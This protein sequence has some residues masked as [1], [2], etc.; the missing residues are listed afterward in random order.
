MKVRITITARHVEV[1]DELRAR[2]RDLVSRLTKVAARPHSARVTFGEDHGESMIEIQVL[3]A[4]GK[5]HVARGLGVDHRTA[6]DR[7]IGRLR[8]QAGR[9]PARVRTLQRQGR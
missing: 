2:A 3:A 5:V 8:R 7:A 1:S 9:T 4:R 6:L